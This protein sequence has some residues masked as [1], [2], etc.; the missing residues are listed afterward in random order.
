MFRPVNRSSYT[1][2]TILLPVLLT[3]ESLQSWKACS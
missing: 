1:L 2:E 3:R